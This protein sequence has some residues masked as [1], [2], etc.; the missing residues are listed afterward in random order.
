M[1]ASE[2]IQR[3]SCTAVTTS[4]SRNAHADGSSTHV[5]VRRTGRKLSVVVDSLLAC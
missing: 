4:G 5:K 2:E 3:T 1:K